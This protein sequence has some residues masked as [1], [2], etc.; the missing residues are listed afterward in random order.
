[1]A[2]KL[3]EEENKKTVTRVKSS[4]NLPRIDNEAINMTIQMEN[5]RERERLEK[6][7]KENEAKNEKVPVFSKPSARKSKY[8]DN[9][10][11]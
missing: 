9:N 10:L 11:Y 2:K 3:Q 7:R 6:E 5:E 4:S 8:C 1:M